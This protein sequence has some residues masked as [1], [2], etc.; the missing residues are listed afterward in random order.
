MSLS[1]R[2]RSWF[3]EEAPVRERP[4]ERLR[5]LVLAQ[6]AAATRAERIVPD[7]RSDRF[8]RDLTRV[9]EGDRAMAGEVR[10]MLDRLGIAGP[11]PSEDV[12]KHD[13]STFQ[14]LAVLADHEGEISRE[15]L[16][17]ASLEEDEPCR[18]ILERAA[19]VHRTNSTEIALAASLITSFVR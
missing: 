1:A 12:P 4:V 13:A 9:A 19:Q 15:A 2:I 6:E 18:A 11:G 16:S 10:A 17:L 8:R 14:R 7:L 3:N 5:N